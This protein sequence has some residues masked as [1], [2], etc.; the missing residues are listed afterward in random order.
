MF[1]DQRIDQISTEQAAVA[2][3]AQ[4]AALPLKIDNP[5]PNHQSVASFTG[6]GSPPCE[7]EKCGYPAHDPNGVLGAD[8]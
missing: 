8:L 2:I 1:E 5:F 7:W 4:A 3:Y 6:H